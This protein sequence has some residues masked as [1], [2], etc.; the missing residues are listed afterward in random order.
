MVGRRIDPFNGF[1]SDDREVEICITARVCVCVCP[2]ACVRV[3][4]IA[5]HKTWNTM[6]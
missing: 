5:E 4:K 6:V 2:R 3:F 1:L